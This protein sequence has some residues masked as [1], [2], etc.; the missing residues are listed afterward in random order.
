MSEKFN[1]YEYIGVI[2]PGAIIVAGASLAFPEFKALIGNDS[3][4]VGGLG[5]FL[6]FSFVLGHLLQAFG[7]LF[8]QFVWK[9]CGGLP[10]DW[11]RVDRHGLLSAHQIQKMTAKLSANHPDFKGPSTVSNKEWYSLT[12]EIY[13]SVA[14]TGRTE[15]IDSFNRTYGLLRGIAVAFTFSTVAAGFLLSMDEWKVVAALATASLTA[16]YRMYR[17]GVHY[18]RELFV[19]YIA[20]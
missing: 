6:I 11:V 18:A 13:A 17:F 19:Q 4:S 9:C 12:R 3:V 10:S 2:A 5:L 14:A 16:T 15:R 20:A 1:A 7:N 8:E